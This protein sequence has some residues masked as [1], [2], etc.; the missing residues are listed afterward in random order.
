[1][2]VAGRVEIRQADITREEVD[3]IVN[4]ANSRLANGGGV[5]GAIS[6]AAGPELQRA[7]D[8][9]IDERG[10]VSTGEAVATDAFELP[11]RKVIHAVGPIYGRHGGEEPALLAAAHRSAI[12]LAAELGL[13]TM[14]I[15]AISCGIYGYPPDRAAPIAIS[16]T[17]EALGEAAGIERVRFCF[18][19]ERERS[20]FERALEAAPATNGQSGD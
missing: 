7:C 14:A 13:R 4:A 1:M 2:G 16:A 11:C 20:A 9:L 6:K 15:P 17:I 18:I 10:P 3:V 8:R 5:A 12:G 19:G